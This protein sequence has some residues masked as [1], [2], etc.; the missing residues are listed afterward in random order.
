[1]KKVLISG[2]SQGIGKQLVIDFV[3]NGIHTIFTYRNSTEKAQQLVKDLNAEGYNNV[4]MFKCDMGSETEVRK[5]FA[6]NKQLLQDIDILIN[7]A[8]IRDPKLNGNPKPFIMTTNDE[9]WYVVQNNVNSV[10]NA[11]REVLP[12]MIRLKKGRIINITSLAGIVGNPGQS[13]Y[14]ASKGAITS[15]S[16][17][18]SKE[19]CSFGICINCVAPGFI[20]TEMVKGLP[21]KYLEARIS[22]S[23]LKRMG[24]TDE[25]SNLVMYLSLNAPM[26]LLNKE[27]VIDGGLS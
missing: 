13:A 6:E 2:G 5:L 8:G 26:F 24:T 21:E 17:S 15:F 10:I 27:I 23:L 18:I 22:N 19:V 4:Q 3:K 14:A 20:E 12:N 25:V 9:W 16:K 1:M 11:C 7:N